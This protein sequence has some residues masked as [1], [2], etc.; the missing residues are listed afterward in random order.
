LQSNGSDWTTARD[1][2]AISLQYNPAIHGLCKQGIVIE[3]RVDVVDGVRHGYFRLKP[4]P[5][6]PQTAPK[7]E[8]VTSPQ[9]WLFSEPCHVDPEE[10]ER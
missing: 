3:N 5:A 6:L 7:T 8:R 9:E 2:S 4:L 10:V 1:L